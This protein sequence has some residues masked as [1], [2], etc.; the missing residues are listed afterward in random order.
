MAKKK[1]EKKPQVGGGGNWMDTYSDMVTL[2]LCFFAIMFN[3]D[4]VTVDNIAAISASF[5]N[6]G[7]GASAGGRTLSDGKLASGGYNIN[8]L[9]AM[10]RGKSMGTA[11]Q[12]AVSLFASEIRSNKIR[13][14][15]DERGLIISLAS[16]AFFNP[17][18]DQ[19]N[20][21]ETRDILLRLAAFLSAEDTQANKLRIEG[22]TD[23]IPVDPEGPWPS[24]WHLSTSR[25]INVLASLANLG[26][27]E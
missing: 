7:F 27:N 10:S 12:K 17:A 4:D 8:S 25:S 13:I 14:S 6:M 18:S 1:R 24:N 2:L 3:P 22:H 26:L 21:E 9:P 15:A 20:V 23:A 19:I 11:Q 5:A 16:D